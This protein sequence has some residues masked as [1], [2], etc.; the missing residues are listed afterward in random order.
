MEIARQ[1]LHAGQEELDLNLDP[2][3]AGTA[4]RPAAST[5]ARVAGMRSQ[6]LWDVLEAGYERVGFRA[7]DDEAFEDLVLGRIVEPTSK[8]DT[9]RVLGDIGVRAPS[10]R[11]VFRVLVRCVERDYRGTLA[12]ACL[13]YS[14]RTAP[15]RASLVLYDCTTLYFET[16]NEDESDED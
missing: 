1:Q 9:L 12:K 16:E 4:G 5:G 14:A 7:V 8:A 11:T 10:L 13:A 15:G 6:L 2:V 3:M